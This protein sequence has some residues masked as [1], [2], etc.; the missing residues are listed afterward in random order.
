MFFLAESQVLPVTKKQKEEKSLEIVL[1][2]FFR[3]TERK[4]K[5]FV[6]CVLPSA[7]V[8]RKYHVLILTNVEFN[9]CKSFTDSSF[10]QF[11]V[12]IYARNF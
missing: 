10:E 5:K 11:L 4:A 6:K 2:I 9:S 7:A 1:C 3:C 8:F 12:Q